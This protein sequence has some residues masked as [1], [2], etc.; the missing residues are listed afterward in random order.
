MG[1]PEPKPPNPLKIPKSSAEEEVPFP[2]S[3]PVKWE[4]NEST[5]TLAESPSKRLRQETEGKELCLEE[6]LQAAAVRREEFRSWVLKKAQTKKPTRKN[7]E[8]RR[9][10]RLEKLR[11]RQMA[12]EA[13]R[14]AALEAV[15]MRAATFLARREG[16]RA[17][18]NERQETLAS[19]VFESL[20]A[21]DERRSALQDAERERLKVEHD[22]V[23]ARLATSRAEAPPELEEARKKLEDRLLAAEEARAASLAQIAARAG[24]QVQHA[25]DVSALTRQ[26][27]LEALAAKRASAEARMLSARQRRAMLNQSAPAMSPSKR[28]SPCPSPAPSL[29]TDQ[30]TG[31]AAPGD[32]AQADAASA[33]SVLAGAFGSTTSLAEMHT[34]AGLVDGPSPERVAQ[35]AEALEQAV[36]EAEAAGAEVA[37][38]EQEVAELMA[39][40]EVQL[41]ARDDGGLTSR[42]AGQSRAAAAA[43]FPASFPV[44]VQEHEAGDMSDREEAEGGAEEDMDEGAI[45]A[46]AQEKLEARMEAFRRSCSSRKLQ[47]AWRTF[48]HKRHTTDALARAFVDTGAISPALKA[49]LSA[50][51]RAKSSPPPLDQPAPLQQRQQEQQQQ[52]QPKGATQPQG[53]S[54]VLAQVLVLCWAHAVMGWGFFIFQ[55]WIPLYLASLGVASSTSTGLLAG[56]PWLAAGLVGAVAGNLADGFIRRGSPRLTVRRGAHAISTLGCAACAIPLAAGWA[57]T[58]AAA[59]AWLVLF[60]SCYAFS[61]GGFH[62]YVQDVAQA[63]AGKL[64]GLTNSCSIALGIVGNLCTGVL[65]ES[66]G[67]YSIVFLVTIG[68]YLT[69]LAAFVSF[70]QGT[71]LELA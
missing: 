69:S 5:K 7:P 43:R 70:L 4:I 64:L 22:T 9:A 47:A 28:S 49:E 15:R 40:G 21:A 57:T 56:M 41:K 66:T 32:A 23:L 35:E 12:A 8:E 11:E 37:Q 19:R 62:A 45:Q 59:T 71:P 65:V 39:S 61:F 46:R 54:P 55:S 50:L 58:P 6:R 27:K 53:A 17:R 36:A 26:L 25:R 52:Q 33:V 68:L 60:Q 42:P 18:V 30:V 51:A 31:D 44:D 63:S 24:E 3:S 1:D 16:A 2:A 29:A 67:S 38:A 48:K 34:E 13:S 20:A 10:A 14:E